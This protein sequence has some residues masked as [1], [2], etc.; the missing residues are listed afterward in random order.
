M[1]ERTQGKL[2]A[3]ARRLF[4]LVLRGCD[5]SSLARNRDL[6]VKL[7]AR[8]KDGQISLAV[9]TCSFQPQSPTHAQN[10]SG[11]RIS[12]FRFWIQPEPLR[13]STARQG[14]AAPGDE[15]VDFLANRYCACTFEVVVNHLRLLFSLPP[16][17]PSL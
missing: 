3:H 6:W 17:D 10:Q 11:T 2:S 5:P 1:G 15:I 8:P 16:L 7:K 4:N 14:D 9:E 13:F 12:W